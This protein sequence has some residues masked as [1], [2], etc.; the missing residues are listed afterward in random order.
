M[1]WLGVVFYHKSSSGL[2]VFL[3]TFGTYV[4]VNFGGFT[5]IMPQKFLNIT[6]IRSAFQYGVIVV[7]VEAYRALV[8]S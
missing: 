6:Q 7:L 4:C 8:Q 3:Q 2:L 1:G 5:T